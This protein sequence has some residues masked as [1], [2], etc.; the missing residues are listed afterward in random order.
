LATYYTAFTEVRDKPS[1]DD[2][3]TSSAQ[4]MMD[5]LQHTLSRA[6]QLLWSIV[7]YIRATSGPD[8][9]MGYA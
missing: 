9:S 6:S 7:G 1:T 8:C 4:S 3:T 2:S 5:A